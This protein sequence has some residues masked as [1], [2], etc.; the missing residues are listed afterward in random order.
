MKQII[1]LLLIILTSCNESKEIVQTV[2]FPSDIFY[3]DYNELSISFEGS[4]SVLYFESL[5]QLILAVEDMS[6]AELNGDFEKENVFMVYIEEGEVYFEY[7]YNFPGQNQV[8][9]VLDGTDGSL[10]T[11]TI[12]NTLDVFYGEGNYSFEIR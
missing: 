7:A 8:T 3:I 5:N 11:E 10:S 4:D 2:Y 6:V 1:Y 9:Y 12:T